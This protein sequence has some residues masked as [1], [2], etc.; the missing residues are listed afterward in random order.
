MRDDD[1]WFVLAVHVFVH[2]DGAFASDHVKDGTFG[3]GRL[4]SLGGSHLNQLVYDG[5]LA[6]MGNGDAS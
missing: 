5:W 3:L 2:V 4:G 1:F 6:G